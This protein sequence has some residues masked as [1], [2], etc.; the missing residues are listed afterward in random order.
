MQY[1]KAMWHLSAALTITHHSLKVSS[2]GPKPS[3]RTVSVVR[4]IKIIRWWWSLRDG[5]NGDR[6][7]RSETTPQNQRTG[8]VDAVVIN[9]N[10]VVNWAV[11]SGAIRDNDDKLSFSWF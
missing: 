9:R 8:T 1:A 6:L 10:S 7:G 2:L 5:G 11:L 3:A 4:R